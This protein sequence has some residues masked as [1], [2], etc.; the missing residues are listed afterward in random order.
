MTLD[1]VATRCLGSC[2]PALETRY[3]GSCSPALATRWFLLTGP[4][5]EMPWF[6]LTGPI[7]NGTRCSKH[8]S[9]LELLLGARCLLHLVSCLYMGRWCVGEPPHYRALVRWSTSIIGRWCV[10]EPTHDSSFI[11]R[12][13]LHLKN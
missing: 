12:R 13:F 1:A 8:C 3:L 11:R 6:L 9:K 4:R 5:N 7:K 2:S 10:G